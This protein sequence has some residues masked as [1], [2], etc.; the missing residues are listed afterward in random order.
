MRRW[1][2]ASD[3]AGAKVCGYHL[4]SLFSNHRRSPAMRGFAVLLTTA[5]L[6]GL[7]AAVMSDAAAQQP[8][9]AATRAATAPSPQ[10]YDNLVALFTAWRTFQQPKLVNGVPDYSRGRHGRAAPRARRLPAPPRR[11]RHDR[12]ADARAGR[13]PHRARRD[14]RPRLR[15]S[16]AP[17][18]GEQPGVLHDRL[19]RPERSAGARRPARRRCGRAVEL[20]VPAVRA[21]TLRR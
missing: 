16:G 4:A 5:T 17:A 1:Y 18:V 3:V 9:A 10:R 12:L 2:A 8:S 13:L 21:A 14:E 6:A 19:R 15:S 7:G 11:A 20:H